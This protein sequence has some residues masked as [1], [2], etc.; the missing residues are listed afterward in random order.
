MEASGFDFGGPG[1]DFGGSEARFGKVLERFSRDFWPEC[2]ESQERQERL[3]KQYLDHKSAKD[4]WPAVVPPGGFQ[5][6]S[7]KVLSKW[8]LDLMMRALLSHLKLDVF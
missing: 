5:W 1:L 6:N 8:L 3:P 7:S 4:G 2:Q